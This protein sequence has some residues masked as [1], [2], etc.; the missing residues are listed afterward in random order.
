MACAPQAPPP[1]F[2]QVPAF[3]GP[4]P[5]G[6]PGFALAPPASPQVARTRVGLLLPLSGGNA[7]LGQAMLDAAQ[8][9]LFEQQDPRVEFLPRDTRG[10]PAGA[11]SAARDAL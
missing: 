7:P 10:T 6:G 3:G 9:A 1:G 11:A 8:L 4:P 2:G 5:P